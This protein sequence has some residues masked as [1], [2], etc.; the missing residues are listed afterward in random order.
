MISLNEALNLVKK[1]A[2]KLK[3]IDVSTDKALDYVVSKNIYSPISFPPF[4]QSAMDGYAINCVYESNIYAIIDE[5]KTGDCAVHLQVKPGEAIRIFTGAMIPKGTTHVVRQ[6]D[7]FLFEDKIKIIVMP[8]IGANIRRIG[9]QIQKDELAIKKGTILNPGAIGYLT[10]L[11]VTDVPVYSKPKITIITTGNELVRLGERLGAGKIYESNS[12][13]LLAGLKKYGFNAKAVTV[14]DSYNEVKDKFETEI[15]KCDLLIFTGGISV[16]DYDFVGK[17]LNDLNVNTLFYKVKQKPG[18]PIFFGEHNEK[19]IFGLPG[20]P[21]AVLTSFYLYVLP[22]IEKMTGREIGFISRCK[23]GL[24]EN[25]SK[26][27]DITHLLKGL[28]Y[29]DKVELL[30]AQSSAMLSSFVTANC[31]AVFEEG[32]KEWK[33]GDLVEIYMI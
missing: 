29:I 27:I 14:K 30:P 4:E 33:K 16:G 26:S 9:E 11:G 19:M 1:Y 8:K 24:L 3:K 10:M 2:K 5:V 7:A 22:C 13:T 32:K 21:A 17:V 28:S 18:K 12:N 23:V 15:K 25:Y 20:N 31:I 6:E